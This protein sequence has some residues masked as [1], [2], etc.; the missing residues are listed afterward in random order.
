VNYRNVSDETAVLLDGL[1][2]QVLRQLTG[3]G[4]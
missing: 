2:K 3:G 1:E 4:R